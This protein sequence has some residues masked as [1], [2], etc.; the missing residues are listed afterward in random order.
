MLKNLILFTGNVNAETRQQEVVGI[1]TDGCVFGIR[2]VSDCLDM[3]NNLN[4][5]QLNIIDDCN[6]NSKNSNEA[7]IKADKLL[8]N[9]HDT[10]MK[11]LS[12]IYDGG[13]NESN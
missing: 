10:W 11:N 3:A 4:L 7:N 12:K 6:R 2:E 5:I 8:K 1:K 9:F 13:K